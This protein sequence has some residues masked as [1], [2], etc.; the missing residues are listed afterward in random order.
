MSQAEFDKAAEEVKHLK[1]KPADDEMLF[2]YSRYKQATVGDI[3]KEQ[4]GMMDLKG[5]AKWGAWNELKGTTR[6]DAMKAYI[7][8]VEEL[9]QKY[10]I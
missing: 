4:P 5:R 2:L 10:G 9:K 1:S 6:E 7:G 3:D 8:K